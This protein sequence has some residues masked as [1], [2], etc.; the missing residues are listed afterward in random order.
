MSK[1]ALPTFYSKNLWFHVIFNFLIHFQFILIWCKKVVQFYYF[2]YICPLFQISVIEESIF[3]PLYI[4]VSLFLNFQ[5]FPTDLCV[6]CVCVCVCLCVLVQ[7]C[8][9]TISLQ[10]FEIKEHDL[11]L[12]F[13]SQDCFMISLNFRIIYSRSFKN[14]SGILIG[15]ALSL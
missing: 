7:Y 6:M 11:R 3:F 1:N 15:T 2:A 14:V 10:Q 8:F 13:Y 12:C 4:L 5:L 9:V